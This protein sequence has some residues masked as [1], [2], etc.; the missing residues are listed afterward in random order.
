MHLAL[1]KAAKGASS[2]AGVG[3]SFRSLASDGNAFRISASGRSLTMYS[4]LTPRSFSLASTAT[5]QCRRSSSCSAQLNLGH[6]LSL[7]DTGVLGKPLRC[8]TGCTGIHSL[9]A[10]ASSCMPG[11]GERSTAKTSKG[12]RGARPCTIASLTTAVCMERTAPVRQTATRA[13]PATSAAASALPRVVCRACTV[14]FRRSP[15]LGALWRRLVDGLRSPAA[16]VASQAARTVQRAAAMGRGFGTGG[17]RAA[18][19]CK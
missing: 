9:S 6:V 19:P 7:Q 4:Y 2:T 13:F 1:S 17:P 16:P 10:S 18:R 3:A 5:K 12:A 11:C 15:G 14:V 8:T